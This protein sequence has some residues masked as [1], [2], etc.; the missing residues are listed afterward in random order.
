MIGMFVMRTYLDTQ[1]IVLTHPPYA[2]R[3]KV[4][5]LV[6]G[7]KR[8]VYFKASSMADAET[9]LMDAWESGEVEVL[10]K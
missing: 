1:V 7:V 4:G 5:P 10:Q 2:D 6:L 3:G 8:A 9:C